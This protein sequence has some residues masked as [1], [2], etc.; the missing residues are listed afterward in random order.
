MSLLKNRVGRKVVEQVTVK[1]VKTGVGHDLCGAYCDFYLNGKKM[2][3]MNDDGYG[4]EVDIVYVSKNAKETF[5]SFLTEN[6]VADLLFK[7]GWKFMKS[8][9]RINLHTQAQCVIDDSINLW[10][11]AKTL[12][13]ITKRTEKAI[14]F[15]TTQSYR[16][17]SWKKI[18]LAELLKYK[19]GLQSLQ[20]AYDE[21]KKEL[22]KGEKIFNTNLQKLGVKL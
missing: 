20:N 17:L 7:N 10:E 8:A 1:K 14:V 6:N 12:K 2:G 13:K 9:D 16:E 3:Y 18:T 19:N 22:K 4:G 11:E 5:E 15:G 21:A